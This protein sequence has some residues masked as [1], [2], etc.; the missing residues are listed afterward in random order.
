M[1]KCV[2]FDM[3]G[4]LWDASTSVLEAGNEVIEQRLGIKNYL[5]QEIM[6]Q[7]MGL[8]TDEIAKIYFPQLPLKEAIEL[9]EACM[10]YENEYISQHGGKL[11]P[12]VIETLQEL[13]KKY[14]LM[15]VTNAQDGYVEAM[16]AAHPLGKYFEDYETYGRTGKPKG[17]NI[18]LIMER[19]GVSEAVYVGD[20]M[21]DYEACVVANVPMVY[22]SYG[23][24]CVDHY[25]KKIDRFEE[26]L[27]I[28]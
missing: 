16:F 8:V 24:G 12:R 10:D 6:N 9:T 1:K 21:K 18:R 7:V 28:L 17:E 26:L 5:N 23:F 25:W 2:I 22:C 3:D 27:E 4:T 13:S 20:T 15:I 14:R 19:N 11:Y